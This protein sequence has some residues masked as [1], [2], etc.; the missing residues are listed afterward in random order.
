MNRLRRQNL[1]VFELMGD[2]MSRLAPGVFGNDRRQL[3]RSILDRRHQAALTR[4]QPNAPL[5]QPRFTPVDDLVDNHLLR[6]R[7]RGQ[8]ATGV[9]AGVAATGTAGY[10]M[11]YGSG[12]TEGAAQMGT[13]TLQ[14]IGQMPQPGFFGRMFGAP[15][16]QGIAAQY[17]A[18]IERTNPQVHARMLEML[19]GA[20]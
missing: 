12:A 19:Q 8:I 5:P 7:R 4:A 13:G 10:G 18:Q 16:P 1:G 9:G 2:G 20:A 17:M 15:N 3:A 11:G 6:L 14:T